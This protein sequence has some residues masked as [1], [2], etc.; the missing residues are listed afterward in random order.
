MT[1][2]QRR[3]DGEIN[4]RVLGRLMIGLLVLVAIAMVAMWFLTS[5]L[6]EQAKAE[7][8][9]PPLMI[10][11]R[12]QHLP[13]NPRL[14]SDPFTEL[15]ELRATQDM[16]LSSYGW[17][18]EPAG[19]AHIPIGRAMDLLVTHGLPDTPTASASVDEQP[20]D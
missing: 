13:P 2:E 17:V 1:S 10:E 20:G 15:D 9:P 19:L 6:F 4:H 7:D 5:S 16:Q 11:A 8:P 18:D 12:V 3:L 14:Q